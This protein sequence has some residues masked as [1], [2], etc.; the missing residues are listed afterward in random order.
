MDERAEYWWVRQGSDIKPAQVAFVGGIPAQIRMIGSPDAVP[1]A[2][3]EL[4]ERLPNPPAP[5]FRQE[6]QEQA[7]PARPRWSGSLLWLVGI[8]LLILV[9]QCSGSLFDAIR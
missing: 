7:A 5:V 8:L 9:V 1:A 4:I 3:V 6:G 2:S